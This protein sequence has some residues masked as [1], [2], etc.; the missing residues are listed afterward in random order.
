MLSLEILHKPDSSAFFMQTHISL[1]WHMGC[2]QINT[3]VGYTHRPNIFAESSSFMAYLI[4][5]NIGTELPT[6][7]IIY[8]RRVSML[9]VT[10]SYLAS[11]HCNIYSIAIYD[12]ISI[13]LAPV[14]ATPKCFVNTTNSI[15]LLFLAWYRYNNFILLSLGM[16][17]IIIS[18][19]TLI[20]LH[21]LYYFSNLSIWYHGAA[22]VQQ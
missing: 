20:W 14:R 22:G 21:I 10:H 6:A 18:Q 5:G 2:V 1:V 8:L 4:H 11:P 17:S 3:F 7:N 13:I 19:T 12:N 16:K 9:L 15:A